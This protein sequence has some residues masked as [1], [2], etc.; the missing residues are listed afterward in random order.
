[1]TYQQ[2]E[3]KAKRLSELGFRLRLEPHGDGWKWMWNNIP[4]W[5]SAAPCTKG[6][7]LIWAL[8]EIHL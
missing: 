3:A 5:Q 1:M 7:A 2:A 6:V 8:Q 4:M